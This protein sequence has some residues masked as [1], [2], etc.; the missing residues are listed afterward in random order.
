MDLGCQ[1][2]NDREIYSLETFMEQGPKETGHLHLQDR[3]AIC[4]LQSL[5]LFNVGGT[6]AV[7][8]CCFFNISWNT[9]T[10][11]IKYLSMQFISEIIIFK[12]LTLARC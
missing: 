4:H 11:T 6:Y 5:C 8:K 2:S 10:I 3:G 7:L 9:F 12:K 1:M